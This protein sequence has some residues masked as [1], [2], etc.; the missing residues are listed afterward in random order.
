LS[1]FHLAAPSHHDLRPLASLST[2]NSQIVNG[3]KIKSK[4]L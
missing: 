3:E 2:L 4:D 1:R